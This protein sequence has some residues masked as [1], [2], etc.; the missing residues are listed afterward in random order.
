[1]LS[2]HAGS[3]GGA[4]G[5]LQCLLRYIDDGQ[6]LGI[7]LPLIDHWP[8]TNFPNHGPA[9]PAYY[10]GA[11]G[12]GGGGQVQIH[13]LGAITLGPSS[14]LKVNGGAGHGG[15]SSYEGTTLGS[16]TQVS[17]SGGGSGG[18]MILHSTTGLNLASISVGTAGTPGNPTTFFDN[19]TPSYVMQGIG[20]RRGW[21]ISDSSATFNG[22]GATNDVDEDGNGPFS[23]GRGGAG[24][25]GVIQV[26]VPNP[27]TDITYHPSVDAAFKQYVTAEN[28]AN[29]AISDRQDALLGLYTLPQAITLVPFY[30][31]ESQLQSKWIDTGLAGQRTNSGSG[32][33]PAYLDALL[34]FDG[35][36]A[37]TGLVNTTANTVTAGSTVGSDSGA[38]SATF[39]NYSVTIANPS[40][41]FADEFLLNPNLLIGFDVLPNAALGTP[42]TFE[43]VSATYTG[44]P[45]ASESLVLTT[46]VSDGPMALHASA[47][48][49][50]KSK[51]F[52]VTTSATKDRLPVSASVRI[53]FQGTSATVGTNNP[54]EAVKTAWTGDGGTTTLD[55]LDGSRFI[56]YRITFDIDALDAG[57]T[58]D[59]ERPG[60][61]YFKLPFAW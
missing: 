52:R 13:A 9:T 41:A 35:I 34:H 49:A 22:G 43:I 37:N 57:P 47:S 38:G 17:G 29:P 16:T 28:L 53:Q 50:V 2:P 51:F 4:S 39:S 3:G 27:V 8:D 10:R 1:M 24:A 11:S 23:T 56:R 44:P 6:G 48:W 20:G 7:P 58:V 19:L 31:P 32:T 60:L 46:R 33:Y 5:D 26:H 45:G 25:S 12:G 54:N 15:E 18:H 36:D 30:S 40:N 14:V 21:A 59:K 42:P 55:T 61:E